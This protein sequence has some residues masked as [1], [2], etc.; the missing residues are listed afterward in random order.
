MSID[1]SFVMREIGERVTR[2]IMMN[3]REGGR[4]VKWK[5][6]QRSKIAHISKKDGKSR[7]GKTLIDTGKLM[8]SI[9]YKFD[10]QTV[11]VGTNIVYASTHQFGAKKS[12]L[13]SVKSHQRKITQAFGRPIKAK[14][15]NV[16]AHKRNITI[17]IEARPFMMLQD[18]DKQYITDLAKK[19]I[20]GSL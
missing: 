8:R 20:Q 5:P 15:V 17:N 3:F 7:L 11:T 16:S 4:P 2:S 13:Q 6:S 10:K 9:H 12:V 1:V 19:F 18:S 14:M